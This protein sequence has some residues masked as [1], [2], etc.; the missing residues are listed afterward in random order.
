MNQIIKAV[1]DANDTAVK[2][3][4]KLAQDGFVKVRKKLD[5]FYNVVL[6][7]APEE[8]AMVQEL[9]SINT[10][11]WVRNFKIPLTVIDAR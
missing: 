5:Y 2:E 1:N 3:M 11:P 4:N 6:K 9:A 10:E 8:G 7:R